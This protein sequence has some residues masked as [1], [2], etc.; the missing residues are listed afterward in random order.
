[1]ADVKWIKIVTDI[2]DDEKIL[3]I[4]SLPD[5]D[6]I[7]VIW[8][9][10]LCLAGKQNNGGVFMIND[11]IHYTDEMFATIFRRPL[12][13]VRLALDAF[14]RYGM[15]ERINE[16]V[17][18]PNWGKHQC[19]EQMEKRREYQRQYHVEYR[20]KQKL[21]AEGKPEEAGEDEA[22]EDAADE[23]D[24]PESRKC[25]RND[26][27]Q[28]GVNAVD[29]NKSKREN[30]KKEIIKER[31]MTGRDKRVTFTPP[32]LEE[33]IEYARQKGFTPQEFDPES[34]ISFYASKGWKVGKNKM[35]NWHQAASGWVAR[36][37]REHPQEKPQEHATP[38]WELPL[39]ERMRIEREAEERDYANSRG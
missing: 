34:F 37:R 26:L 6:S 11:R 21:L 16:T 18:I 2:F 17:T 25:L 14:E 31:K 20:K 29:K 9:K 12:N 10:L 28:Q 13:T 35:E 22:D 36:Y 38:W 23:E 19:I 15:I 3:L 7:I 4:E 1:M 39:D 30:I 33:V 5:S 27:R 32:T 8:F 24:D